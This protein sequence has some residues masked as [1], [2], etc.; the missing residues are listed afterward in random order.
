MF[1][2]VIQ[3]LNGTFDNFDA[4]R[5]VLTDPKV[6]DRLGD[7]AKAM[8]TQVDQATRKVKQSIEI[9]GKEPPLDER[10]IKPTELAGSFRTMIEKIQEE[11]QQKVIG[12]S[13][14]TLKSLDVEVKA[15]IIAQKGEAT[16]VTPGPDKL[17]D[18]AQISTIR[19]SFGTVPVIRTATASTDV[20][21]PPTPAPA[22]TPT[23]IIRRGAA[24]K[25][26]PAAA[27]SSKK[28][29]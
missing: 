14:A 4:L 26:K 5:K 15:L 17:L 3:L 6:V 13:A 19:M 1:E 12:D 11:S 21:R 24:A 29:R 16:L 7:Q 18:P 20:V 22:P 25:V 9:L 28:K 8:A 2:D 10:I 23:P 27:R